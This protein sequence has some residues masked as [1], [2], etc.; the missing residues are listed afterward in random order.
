MGPTG[1]LRASDVAAS[2]STA[3]GSA[4]GC[5]IV[6]GGSVWCFPLAGPLIDSTP[7]GSGQG[8][9]VAD[10]GARRRCHGG[11]AGGAAARGRAP[12]RREHERWRRRVLRRHDGGRR[13]VLGLRRRRDPRA[14]R[15]G[16]T[17][18]SRAPC[19]RTRRTPF[20]DAA[21]IRPRLQ[22]GVRAQDRRL[23]LV[24]GR[25]QPRTGRR[26]DGDRDDEPVHCACRLPG[27]RPDW[28]PRPAAPRSARSSAAAR[29]RAGAGT[30]TRRPAPTRTKLDRRSHDRARRVQEGRLLSGVVDL[31]PDRGMQAMCASTARGG[32]VCWGHPFQVA[33]AARRD[34]PVFRSRS[35]SRVR[36]FWPCGCRYR[37]SARATVRSMYADPDG[38]LTL[39]AGAFPLP[40]R[41][42]CAPACRCLEVAAVADAALEPKRDAQVDVDV[43]RE[44]WR[45]DLRVERADEHEAIGQGMREA[46]ADAREE[47]SRADRVDAGLVAG[48][49]AVLEGRDRDDVPDAPGA[50]RARDERAAAA[51]SRATTSRRRRR[52]AAYV[53]RMVRAR[54]VRSRRSSGP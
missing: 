16:P 25:R 7:L 20:A 26:R 4:T 33:R 1:H 30:R 52:A 17:P 2:G 50:D 8:A 35:R 11:R 13:L 40:L 48:R 49:A 31:A 15:R 18:A 41:S 3:Y 24:L 14:W 23:R 28:P 46:A 42:P 54:S 6:D 9:G 47:R 5:A 37:R 21:E 44:G 27:P 10:V 45:A 43:E 38:R 39:G 12:A 53:A 34:E 36:Q 22:L 51:P 29:S 19:L 32:L